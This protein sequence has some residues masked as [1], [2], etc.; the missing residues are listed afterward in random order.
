MIDYHKVRKILGATYSYYSRDACK[1]EQIGPPVPETRHVLRNAFASSMQVLDVGC[2]RGDSLLESAPLFRHAIGVDESEAMIKMGNRAKQ[3][4]SIH[5]VDFAV[6]KAANLPLHNHRFD[7]LF[8]ERG[9]LGY[10]DVTLK[11][12]LRVLRPGGLIFVETLGELNLH[13]VG[14]AFEPACQ[15][16][17]THLANLDEERIR[18][19]RHGVRIRTLASRIQTLR[20]QDFYEWLKYQCSVWA[21]LGMTFPSYKQRENFERL[22]SIASDDSGRINI[23][24]HTIW[25]TGTKEKELLRVNS[26][27]SARPRL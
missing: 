14:E 7:F 21:Y 3:S 1:Y 15:K 9:P 4:R 6:G 20:F 23:T 11:E 17:S 19:E 10:N 25:I 5:N 8:S 13:E 27:R 24:Y 18:F 22:V 16:P 2:G 12:A 26:A